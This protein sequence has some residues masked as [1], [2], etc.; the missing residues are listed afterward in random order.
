M[1]SIVC[2]GIHHYSHG[3]QATVWPHT[4]RQMVNWLTTCSFKVQI[5]KL[6]YTITERVM[7]C[8]GEACSDGNAYTT[9]GC[10]ILCMPRCITEKLVE[11]GY[12]FSETYAWH[13]LWYL[14]IWGDRH[15]AFSRLT[16]TVQIMRCQPILTLEILGAHWEWE[17]SK[18]WRLLKKNTDMFCTPLISPLWKPQTTLP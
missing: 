7:E 5:K 3:R 18:A 6:A 1:Y 11:R 16:P 17:K 9:E 12:C 15:N 8:N 10:G 14:A 2:Y 4:Y 13:N